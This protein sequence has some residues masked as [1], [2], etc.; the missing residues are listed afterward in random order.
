MMEKQ[1]EDVLNLPKREFINL[2]LQ[3][4][5]EVNDGKLMSCAPDK[6]PL[7]IWVA[8]NDAK[9]SREMVPNTE[10]CLLCGKP[11]C[12]DC[13]NHVVEQLSRVTGYMST[14]SSWN[15]AKKQEF[16]DRKRYNV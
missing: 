13:G 10:A 16:E 9:C 14:V 11:M 5:K 6:C 3:W 12:P 1:I 4:I 15:E 7:A 8:H 2:N